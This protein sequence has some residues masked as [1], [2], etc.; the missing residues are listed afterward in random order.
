[1]ASYHCCIRPADVAHGHPYLVFDCQG[2]LHLPLIVFAKEAHSRLAPSSVKK[3]LTGILPWFSWLE[4]DGWQV[5]AG[6]RWDDPPETIRGAV[7]EY[8]VGQLQCRAK[9][10]K[11]GGEWL[12]TT[13][14]ATHRVQILLSGLKL[15]YRI[16]QARGYYPYAN[17]LVGLF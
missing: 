9:P 4:T 13:E 5:Q 10:R 3:Y 17:P 11:G 16:A 8:L 1:M 12:E 2:E 6:R 14:E 15:F 7:R